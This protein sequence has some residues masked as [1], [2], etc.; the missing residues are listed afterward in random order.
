[1]PDVLPVDIRISAEGA[2]SIT[3]LIIRSELSLYRRTF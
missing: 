3:R 1:V 2:F